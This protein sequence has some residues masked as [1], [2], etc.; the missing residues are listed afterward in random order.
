MNQ[1]GNRNLTRVRGSVCGTIS[2]PVL[3]SAA[4]EAAGIHQDTER[5][6]DLMESLSR[7]TCRCCPEP[8]CIA[9]TVGIDFRDL[10][11]LHLL[12]EP[13][14]A[15]Q[16]AT[17]SGQAGPFL[18]RRGC[19]LPWRMRPW[20]CRTYICSAQLALLKK[21]G[22]PNPAARCNRIVRIESQRL[23][24]A[25]EVLDRIRCQRPTGSSSPSA[26]PR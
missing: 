25:T 15:Q 24:R 16:A 4:V 11:V 10:L 18:N 20:M 17:E 9:K 23:C 6:S 8:C 22:R 26:G 14:P 21:D 1:G 5:L 12:N 7:R 2:A 3:S 19:R 13:I